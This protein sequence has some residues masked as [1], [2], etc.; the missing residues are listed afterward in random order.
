MAITTVHNELI[1][2]NAISGTAIADNAVTSVHIAKN[3]VGTVQIAQNSVTSVSIALNNVTGTQIAMNSITSTQLADNAVTATKIPDGTQLALGATNFSGEIHVGG[4]SVAAGTASLMSD[5]HIKGVLSSGG[6]GDTLIGAISGVSNGHQIIVDSSNNQTY[7]WFN[8]GTNSM[9]ID[10]SGNVGIGNSTPGSYYSNSN[11]LVVGSGAARQGITIASS[12]T[13]IGQ[14]AF[15]DGT[16]GDSRYEGSVL[17]NH[18]D[19]HMEII[20]NHATAIYIDSAQRVGIGTTSPDGP[21]HVKPASGDTYVI[22]EAGQADGNTGL[23]YH[24]NSGTQVGYNLSDTDDN[25]YYIGVDGINR[26][27]V[28]SGGHFELR[29][30]DANSNQVRMMDSSGNIDGYLYAEAGEIGFLD[31]DGNW[32]IQ[33]KTDD[34]VRFLVNNVERL[35]IGTN[36]AVLMGVTSASG[37]SVPVDANSTELNRGYLNLN[38]D[39]TAS[40]D[41]ILFGKDGVTRGRVVTTTAT[42]YVATSDYRRKENVDYTWDAT[43]R[44]KQLKPVR[45]NW[46][47]DDTN[48]LEDGFLAHEV[49]SIVPHIVFGEKDGD[50]L[51]GMDYG[52]LTPL[53]TKALQEAM[54]RIE[55]LEAEVAALKG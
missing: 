6:S 17:Y 24:N 35:R 42:S 51:Q 52:K 10:S 9:I 23:I 50:T 27:K 8:G 39:D 32:A 29:G 41:Q 14:L 19:N 25:I 43:S 38:R 48:T 1:A 21:L 37:P 22:L 55:A 4:T 16:S 34:Y 5:G 49:S 31:A 3:N 11:Q 20:T 13:T 2:V 44:L 33:A 15:A 46:I 45:F 47:D 28:Q 30:P 12:T 36:G 53:L 54:V 7:K 18:N 40:I 26:L